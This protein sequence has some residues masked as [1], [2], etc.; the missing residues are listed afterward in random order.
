MALRHET[1]GVTSESCGSVSLPC[2]QGL[3]ETIE[4][5][6]IL[7][8]VLVLAGLATPQPPSQGG[9]SEPTSAEEVA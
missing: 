1:W 4:D 9:M 5:E 7:T 2:H 3:Q 8:R 6:V